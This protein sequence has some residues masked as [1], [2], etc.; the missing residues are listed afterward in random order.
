MSTTH[1]SENLKMTIFYYKRR[2]YCLFYL[3]Y[4]HE[5]YLAT[6]KPFGRTCCCARSF[7]FQYLC[8]QYCSSF[9]I[10]ICHGTHCF[11]CM[12]SV[13]H[14]LD[15]G[16][17][18]TPCHQGEHVRTQVFS[19]IVHSKSKVQTWIMVE[20][21]RPKTKAACRGGGSWGVM[22]GSPPI[23]PNNRSSAV[24]ITSDRPSATRP[25]ASWAF[26]FDTPAT[27][28]LHRDPHSNMSLGY[29]A[30]S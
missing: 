15:A 9:V 13:A 2:K 28:I 16:S 26:F 19:K 22:P 24:P 20:T 5:L 14:K 23:H 18:R 29:I 1:V 27:K 17:A 7:L 11:R 10:M 8:G 6:D 25:H 3:L 30:P 4:E 21:V 12:T